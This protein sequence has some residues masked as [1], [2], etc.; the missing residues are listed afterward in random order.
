[1]LEIDVL[2]LFP[3]M[4][5]G[6]LAES[7]P[8]RVQA[9]GLATVRF[10][11]LRRWGIGRHRSV[12]DYTF[13]GGPGMVMRP[14]PVAAALDELRRP[15]STVVLLDPAGERFG[16]PMARELT[17]SGHL[18]IVCGRYEGVD[19]RIRE[20]VD[21]EISIGDYVLSG[22]EPAAIV[23]IDAVLR[24]LPGA[25]ESASLEAESFAHE[26]L[27]YPQYTRPRVFRGMAVPDVLVSGD[28]GAVETW[29]LRESLRRTAR[30]RPD[31]LAGR[32]SRPRERELLADLELEDAAR[33]GTRQGAEPEEG[34]G[35]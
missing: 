7:I 25:I 14:E 23:V 22:G 3:A 21:R 11:D 2:T 28:H 15:E 33:R 31:L 27:E 8:G 17:G 34:T 1:V 10:H 35:A 16:Q 24:L 18:V 6:P 29:R 5:E 30:R 9:E 32:E 12:D 19:E 4:L 26:L 13:G 20:M